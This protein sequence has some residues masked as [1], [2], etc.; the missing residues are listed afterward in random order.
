MWHAGVRFWFF[1]ARPCTSRIYS[2]IEEDGLG[3][4]VLPEPFVPHDHIWP[5]RT[6][7]KLYASFDD[8]HGSISARHCNAPR[9]FPRGDTARLVAEVVEL[10]AQGGIHCSVGSDGIRRTEEKLFFLSTCD[11][12]PDANEKC[13]DE[14]TKRPHDSLLVGVIGVH[15]FCKR[16]EG[17]SQGKTNMKNQIFFIEKTEVFRRIAS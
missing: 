13:G 11:T 2:L 16:I 12:R 6:A 17:R 14:R 8:P 15:S 5:L 9:P 3:F 1:I 10:A 4:G 7:R